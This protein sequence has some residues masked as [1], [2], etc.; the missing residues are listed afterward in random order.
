MPHGFFSGVRVE[1]DLLECRRRKSPGASSLIRAIQ[2]DDPVWTE[3]WEI[4][5]SPAKAEAPVY[6]RGGI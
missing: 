4:L 1:S 5:K 6:L 2:P 3:I